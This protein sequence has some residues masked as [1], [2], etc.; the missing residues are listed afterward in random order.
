M[1]EKSAENVIRA[2]AQSK[3]PELHRFLYALGIRHVGEHTAKVLAASFGSLERLQQATAEELT[4]IYEIGPEVAKSV[5]QYFRQA[6]TETLLAKFAAGGVV[7]VNPV[8]TPTQQPLAGKSFVLTGTLETYSRDQA[9]ALIE[10]AGGRVASS[11][12]KKTDYVVAG[13][14]AGSKLAKAEQLGVTILHETEFVA[15]LPT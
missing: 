1:A 11:V 8:G 4:S 14:D 15:L 7:L 5:F 2:I 13:R 12:S 9:Q 3:R 10:K 6:A